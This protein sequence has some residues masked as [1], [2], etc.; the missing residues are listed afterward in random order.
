MSRPRSIKGKV[1]LEYLNRF[2]KTATQTLARKMYDEN[3]ELFS[4]TGCLCELK[5]DYMPFN[6]WN[7]GFAHINVK[8]N[9]DYT[10]KNM[11]IIN[12]KIV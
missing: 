4:S 5:P 8:P 6:K 2:P 12:G 1:I 11:R 7:L 9:G 10:V 3:K